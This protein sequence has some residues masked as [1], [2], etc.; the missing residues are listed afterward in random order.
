[1]TQIDPTNASSFSFVDQLGSAHVPV[2]QESLFIYLQTRLGGIDDEINGMFQKQEKLQRIHKQLSTITE[3]INQFK[4]DTSDENPL[5]VKTKDHH[6]ITDINN[7]IGAIAT[8]DPNLAD[9]I[10][11]SLSKDGVLTGGV[12]DDKGTEDTSDDVLGDYKY[13]TYEAKT[14]LEYIKS[15]TQELESSGQLEMIKL[16]SLMSNKTTAVQLSTN[17]TDAYNQ[18][19]KAIVSNIK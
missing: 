12:L 7:A 10:K 17:M 11:A 8:D 4:T 19:L 1:M 5:D 6:L 13:T 2:S 9:D 15:T 14:S 16:Q 3:A 18:S